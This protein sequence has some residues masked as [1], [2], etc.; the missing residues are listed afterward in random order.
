MIPHG[1][2][3]ISVAALTHTLGAFSGPVLWSAEASPS[4]H[5]CCKGPAS[6]MANYGPAKPRVLALNST[7]KG[8]T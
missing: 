8:P 4:R 2:G 6:G 7:P 3:P 1:T 5:T